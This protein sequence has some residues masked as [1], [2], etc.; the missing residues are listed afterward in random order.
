MPRRALAKVF[1]S[2]QCMVLAMCYRWAVSSSIPPRPAVSGDGSLR[3]Q[4]I[5]R[6]EPLMANGDAVR[7]LVVDDFE[8]WRRQ[9]C[10]M[11]Q[12]RPEFRV[13]GEV[14]GGLEA[15]QQAQE[16]QPD[17]IL[18][19]IAL[20]K[21]NGIEA[22]QQIS[23]IVPA[24]TI[25]FVSQTSDADVVEEA[26]SNGAKGFVWKQDAEIDLVPAVEA[27]LRGARFVSPGVAKFRPP[28]H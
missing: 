28:S 13:V 3:N 20:P 5:S 9:V 18:L 26:L 27:V 15:V 4:T 24:V 17:L 11:L 10:S 16:L 7:I 12:T 1:Y 22:G 2:E 23:R 14:A 21:L 25:L 6:A 8:P 19:D